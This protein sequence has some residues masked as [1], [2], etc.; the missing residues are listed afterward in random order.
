MLWT[1]NDNITAVTSNLEFKY[2]GKLACFDLDGT[3]I[4]TKSNKKFAVDENDWEFLSINVLNK[5]NQLHNNGFC[6]II[7]TNQA[8]LTNKDKINIW[9]NKLGNIISK[10]CLPIQL[11]ASIS[12]GIYRKPLPTFMMGVY[13]KLKNMKLELSTQSF[14]CGDACGRP[15][16][17]SDCDLK[18]ALNTGLMFI[19]PNEFFNEETVPIPKIVYPAFDEIIKLSK[20]NIV[21][22]PQ[23]NEIILM[24]GFPGS[25][26]STFVN[27][28]LLPLDYVRI[29]R[30]TL[31][32]MTRCLNE[33]KKNLIDQKCVVID[34]I[35]HD[36]KAREKYIKLAQ[37]YGYDIRCII[38]DVSLDLA[39]HNSMYRLL[40]NE[41]QYIPGIVYR[42]Y[43]KKYVHPSTTE[44]IKEVIKIKP[45]LNIKDKD[46]TKLYMY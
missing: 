38:I 42:M 37:E 34:N 16:D 19:T 30:D 14:Y 3:L 17:H 46:Y 22:Q 45:K 43:T 32:T 28:V 2:T 15:S 44:G 12:Y 13:Q 10:I 18:F 20:S 41:A 8:G 33:V 6:I 36:V 4:K 11:F 39:M 24:V 21:F 40:K 31:K 5:L 35:N 1:I 29:N 27:D 23:N 7:I 9:K 26:K 25:G